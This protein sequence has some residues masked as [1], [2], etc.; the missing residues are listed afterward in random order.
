MSTL[1]LDE[2]T[3]KKLFDESP[4]WFKEQLTEAFGKGCFEKRN[5]EGIKTFDD[6]CKALGV[7][8]EEILNENDT[9]DENAYKKLKVVAKA[10]NQKWAPDWENTD[11]RKYYP[12]FVLS[13]GFGFSH[14]LFCC[15]HT[16]SS[17]GSRLC[18]ET[19]DQASYAGQQFIELYRI[20]LT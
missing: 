1:K 13:S 12:Y 18:F 20:F 3:A 9:P 6:A 11:Q 4:D 7:S 15:D 2:Q 5:Y 19:Y 8:P 16:D 10:I 17:V 14:S